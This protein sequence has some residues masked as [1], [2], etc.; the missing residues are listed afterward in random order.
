[1]YKEQ[2]KTEITSIKEEFEH[3]VINN[4]VSLD[5]MKRITT[6]GQI[7]TITTIDKNPMDTTKGLGIST[8]QR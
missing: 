7:T 3:N 6:V 2:G 1:M 4:L 5:I 8:Q